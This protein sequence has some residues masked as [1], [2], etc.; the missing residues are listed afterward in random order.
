MTKVELK[1]YRNIK[2]SIESIEEQIAR[3]QSSIESP[4]VQQL[5]NVPKSQSNE[6]SIARAVEKIS[7]L[8][9]KY[10]VKLRDLVDKQIKI[11]EAIGTL[12][13]REQMLMRYRYIDSM[14]WEQ[15][16]VKIN[17]S[18][19]HVVHRLHPSAL[20]KIKM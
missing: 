18:Y 15:I 7:E 8:Q 12:P 17:Y 5:S 1:E 16:A 3:L 9:D 10:F 14:T 2:V 19:V 13:H 11:E 20:A 6:D 4:K